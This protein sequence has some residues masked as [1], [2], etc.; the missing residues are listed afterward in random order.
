MEET[1]AA[2][3]TWTV[4]LV[5]YTAAIVKWTKDGHMTMDRHM[6]KLLKMH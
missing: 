3:N 1:L 2:I 4:A 5:R 6:R